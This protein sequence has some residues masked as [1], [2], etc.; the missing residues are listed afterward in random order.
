M[1]CKV[2]ECDE[3]ELIH[4]GGTVSGIQLYGCPKCNLVY[5]WEPRM[6]NEYELQ[7]ERARNPGRT[8]Q[9]VPAPA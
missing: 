5:Y 1:K 8:V 7:T 4:L 2:K 3:Q 6:V 9:P